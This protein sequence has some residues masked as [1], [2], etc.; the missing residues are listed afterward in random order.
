MVK[1]IANIVLE[2]N[3]ENRDINVEESGILKKAKL[4]SLGGC[5]SN[6]VAKKTEC[7]FI[8]HVE[9]YWRRPTIAL[10]AKPAQRLP[11]LNHD[12]PPELSRYWQDD[13][14]KN[15]LAELLIVKGD[16]LILDITRDLFCKVIELEEG[17]FVV[18]PMSVKGILWDG[19][20][21]DEDVVNKLIGKKCS[22]VGFSDS[23]YFDLWKY[24]FNVFYNT[25]S[26]KFKCI[27]INEIY[28]TNTLSSNTDIRFR[29]QSY[30][31][32]ANIF[33]DQAYEYIKSNY[34]GVIF[35]SIT[36]KAMVTGS[37]VPGEGPAYT[38]FINEAIVLFSENL[39]QIISPSINRPG[40]ILI[41]DAIQRAADYEDLLRARKLLSA[42][43]DDLAHR[44]QLIEQQRNEAGAERDDLAHR[45]QLVSNHG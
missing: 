22:K 20:N 23:S 35:N 21:V 33:L 34:A 41:R 19:G 32:S 36:R 9:H 31:D 7:F 24:Y 26:Q 11:F 43:R 13:F 5:V 2:Q 44:L 10:M 37:D 40:S 39:R 4:V 38:H 45:L 6:E 28:F 14:R 29:D 16:I 3:A 30:V 8:K 25:F 1:S 12:F 42:E 18:D 27:I 17:C 15:H